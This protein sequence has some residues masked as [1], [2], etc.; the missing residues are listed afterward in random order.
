[1]P[2]RA[3]GASHG[4][5]AGEALPQHS[6]VGLDAEVG[7]RAAHA[8]AEARDH[9][10]GNVEYIVLLAD[11]LEAGVVTFR[12]NDDAAG[13]QDRLRQKGGDRVGAQLSNPVLELRH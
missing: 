4:V 9:L 11:R 10:V 1:M 6:E 5:A 8:D 3:D 13:R 7:L 2:A 12:R